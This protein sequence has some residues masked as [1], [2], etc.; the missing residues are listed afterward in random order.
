MVLFSNNELQNM[1]NVYMQCQNNVELALLRYRQLYPNERFPSKRTM[2]RLVNRVTRSGAVFY[3]ARNP[4][5]N[6]ILNR[7]TLNVL[8]CVTENP[9]IGQR[10]IARNLQISK[11][12]IQRILKKENWHAYKSYKV[13]K[14][15]PEDW[16]KR[17]D[18]CREIL[19]RVNDNTLEIENV[20]FTDESNFRS[21]GYINRKNFHT[22]ASENPHAIL[23]VNN[24]GHFSITVWCGI[25]GDNVIGPHFFNR[26]NGET[27]LNFLHNDLPGMLDN[28]LVDRRAMFFQQDGAP[29]HFTLDVREHLNDIYEDRWIGRGGPIPWPPRSPDLTPLDFYL[30]SHLK[31][32]V[33]DSPTEDMD[34]LK[35]KIRDAVATITPEI[36]ARVR[37]SFLRRLN[38]CV[39]KLGRNIEQF[40]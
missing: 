26:V 25:I 34:H 4:R 5:Q 23:E 8:L 32:Q 19:R 37:R 18:F 40:L 39:E 2:K 14:L 16:P 30:W 12:T 17:L 28:I 24:Q 20:L 7:E 9:H 21:D 3:K 13:Q 22:Y 38:F 10:Q 11:T 29:P 15:H 31:E 33:Y 36:L 1:F 27:Y 6:T 35:Q